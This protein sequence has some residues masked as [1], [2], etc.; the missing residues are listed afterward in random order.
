MFTMKCFSRT[1]NLSIPLKCTHHQWNQRT[2]V[3]ARPIFGV[4]V[5]LCMSRISGSI[6]IFREHHSFNNSMKKH[7]WKRLFCYL[8]AFY[9]HTHTRTH[10]VSFDYL[11]LHICF[12]KCNLIVFLVFRESSILEEFCEIE[13]PTEFRRFHSFH[14]EVLSCMHIFFTIISIVFPWTEQF[15]D[16]Y[17]FCA[18]HSILPSCR[19]VLFD[20]VFV[21]IVFV[22]IT[23]HVSVFWCVIKTDHINK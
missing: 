9:A 2:F 17:W 22:Q 16:Y 21:D 13:N 15:I 6:E 5:C 18:F 14:R 23:H 7:E 8:L 11:N 3:Y 4:C 12:I 1:W 20:L 19:F 10:N